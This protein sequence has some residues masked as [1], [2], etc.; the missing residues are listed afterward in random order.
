[1]QSWIEA[2]LRT[3][4]LNHERLEHR[5]QLVL[6]RLA[7]KPSFKF[8]AACRGRAEVKAA[9]RFVNTP[10]VTP[11]AILAPHRDATLQRIGQYRVVIVAQDTT[12]TDLTRKH[13]RL[14]G[15]GPLN[16]PNRLGFHVHNLLAMPPQRLPLGV[17]AATIW[18]RDPQEFGKPSQR[19]QKPIEQKESFRWLD[20]YRQACAV[21]TTCPH[22][23]VVAVGDSENDI[24]ECILEGQQTAACGQR[25]ADWIIRACQERVLAPDPQAEKSAAVAETSYLFAK[26]SATPV[27][28]RLT[29]KVSKREPKSKDNRKRKQP[30]SARKAVVTVQ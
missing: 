30:R 5:F 7:R 28:Q 4:D 17:V 16:G 18:A 24:Y 23:Q 21:A 11:Q 15:A 9:Y 12:E 13:E 19:K 27:L 25:K 6:D 20:G 14:T 3:A 2:E 8:T 26:V 29:I 22:T 10:R 1:M